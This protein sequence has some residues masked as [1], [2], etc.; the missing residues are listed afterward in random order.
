MLERLGEPIAPTP[1]R[2]YQ[3]N[4][5]FFAFVLFKYVKTAKWNVKNI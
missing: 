5:L 3:T 4:T 2:K 1:I